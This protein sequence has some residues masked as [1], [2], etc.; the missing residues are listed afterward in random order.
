MSQNLCRLANVLHRPDPSQ[1]YPVSVGTGG[2]EVVFFVVVG[3]LVVVMSVIV[4]TA[5]KKLLIS[6]STW[7]ESDGEPATLMPMFE[8]VP[9]TN[10]SLVVVGVAAQA[11][12]VWQRE[13]TVDVE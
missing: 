1:S 7:L 10:P 8:M 9:S 11:V 6:S 3:L 13:V 2:A 12:M 5:S 4:N